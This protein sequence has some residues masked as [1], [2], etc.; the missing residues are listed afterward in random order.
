MDAQIKWSYFQFR[1]NLDYP[2]YLRFRQDELTPKFSHL[3]KEL[4]FQELEEK[5]S[6]KISLERPQTKILTVQFASAR[7]N[8]QLNGTDLLDKYGA[9]S[10]SIQLGTPVYT[11][12]RV[13]MMAMPAR[14]PLWDLALNS[15]ISQTDQMIGVRIVLVRFLTS[16]LSEQG[17]LS[18][19]GT[20]KDDVVVVMKQA[21]SFGEAVFIDWNKKVIYSNAGEMK[22][23]SYMKLLRKDKDYSIS[24]QMSREDIISFLSVS[25]CML[26][27]QG[28]T[29]A[30]KRAIYELSAV[31]S[32]SYAI[33]EPTLNL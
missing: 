28:I 20:M 21:Q 7:L 24:G 1:K 14:K 26:S 10:L 27:F 22:L 19:W 3:F 17:V 25:T 30:M 29:P 23:N 33:C 4:G 2:I 18:Y 9:E 32:G 13:G 15:E 12:R 11:Y 31:S 16:A 8:Q 6:K 5:E